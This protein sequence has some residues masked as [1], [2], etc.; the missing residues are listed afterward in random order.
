ML[1]WQR[2]LRPDERAQGGRRSLTFYRSFQTVQG[3]I[4]CSSVRWSVISSSLFGRRAQFLTP[5]KAPPKRLASAQR[6]VTPAPRGIRRRPPPIRLSTATQEHRPHRALSC[7]FRLL[8]FPALPHLPLCCST[9]RRKLAAH[10]RGK[11]YCQLTRMHAELLPAN[12]PPPAH[13]NLHQQALEVAAKAPA[14]RPP[15][16]HQQQSLKRRQHSAL[17]SL[18][19]TPGSYP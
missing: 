5:F 2:R 1:R 16:Q 11:A 9:R 10:C 13:R 8:I 12:L 7:K 19:A 3:G 18:T 15:L 4:H 14:L 6:R 17:R